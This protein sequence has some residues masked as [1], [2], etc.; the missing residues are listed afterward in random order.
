MAHVH[1][2][3]ST[4][5]TGDD[6]LVGIG[7]SWAR[8]NRDLPG[9]LMGGYGY[10]A[11]TVLLDGVVKVGR[12]GAQPLPCNGTE[13]EIYTAPTAAIDFASA[14]QLVASGRIPV[15]ALLASLD[16]AEAQAEAEAAQS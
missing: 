9:A 7:R 13:G 14:G 15:Q 5:K 3:L 6:S 2:Q 10:G 11:D 16:Q 4:D 1:P 8:I 12:L